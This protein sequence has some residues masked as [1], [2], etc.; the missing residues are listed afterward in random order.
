MSSVPTKQRAVFY[1]T[2]GGADVIRY[3]EDRPVPEPKQG[4]ILVKSAYAGVNFI[5]TCVIHAV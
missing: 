2:K 4:E 5:D 3:A 1:E